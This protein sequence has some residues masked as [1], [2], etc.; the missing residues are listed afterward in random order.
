MDPNTLAS[1]KADWLQCL[2]CCS[3]EVPRSIATYSCYIE[4]G[5]R[6]L[7]HDNLVIAMPSLEKEISVKPDGLR[8][9][10]L[11]AENRI[12][13]SYSTPSLQLALEGLHQDGVVVL[14]GI[15]DVEH[16][17]QLYQHM[18]ADRPRLMAELHSNGAGFNQG[19]QCRIPSQTCRHF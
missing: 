4:N 7:C 13:K 8:F 16:C 3:A 6:A 15:V 9:V 5:N 1:P 14:Q 18:T 12:A 10:P 11:T 19:V 2:V 17:D